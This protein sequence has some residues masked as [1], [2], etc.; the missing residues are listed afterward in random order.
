MEEPRPNITRRRF[1]AGTIATGAAV[2]APGA[3][4][5]A[6][7]HRRRARRPRKAGH[8][9]DVVVVGAGLAGLTAARELSRRGGR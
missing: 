5:A 9:A 8:S 4:E 2:A 1:V 7:R 3:A 6:K